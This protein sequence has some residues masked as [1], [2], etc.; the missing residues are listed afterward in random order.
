MQRIPEGRAPGKRFLTGTTRLLWFR[1]ELGRG[2]K[3]SSYT[4]SGLDPSVG[5]V[6]FDRC[7]RLRVPAWGVNSSV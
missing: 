3:F 5:P 6:Q 7:R 1:Y 2:V 4:G